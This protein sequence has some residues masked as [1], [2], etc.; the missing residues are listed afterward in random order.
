M[1]IEEIRNA[2]E[3]AY[4]EIGHAYAYVGQDRFLAAQIAVDKAR[5]LIKLA[6][7]ALDKIQD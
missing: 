2:L 5:D 1:G 3:D 4:H 7:D 6:H